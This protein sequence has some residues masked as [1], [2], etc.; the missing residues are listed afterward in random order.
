[1]RSLFQ[2][3]MLSYGFSTRKS[4]SYV[5]GIRSDAK[6]SGV[7]SRLLYLDSD[8]RAWFSMLDPL[9]YRASGNI[10]TASLAEKET[11]LRVGMVLL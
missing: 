7:C 8:R 4:M 5:G 9:I 11:T 2:R 6:Q 1:M 3:G 10:A